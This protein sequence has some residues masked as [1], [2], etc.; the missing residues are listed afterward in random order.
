MQRA[1]QQYLTH[2]ELD[3]RNAKMQRQVAEILHHLGRDDE[4]YLHWLDA[5]E[6]LL[7]QQHW[8][9]CL[10]LCERLLAINPHDRT[11]QDRLRQARVSRDQMR[12][13]DRAIGE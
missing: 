13:I 10:A 6:I 8:D 5:S 7:A 12:E 9:E 11:V 2:L 3:P 1:L 4:A